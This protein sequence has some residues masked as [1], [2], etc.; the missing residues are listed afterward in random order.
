MKGVD[1]KP[2]SKGLVRFLGSVPMTT[3]RKH[4]SE[5]RPP[6]VPLIAPASLRAEFIPHWLE[7]PNPACAELDARAPV[8]L[9]ARGE[10][11]AI[12]NMIFFFESGVPF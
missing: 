4:R 6:F 12:E 9:M 3:V 1:L 11:Q 10:Y 2:K 5:S 7:T 8:D